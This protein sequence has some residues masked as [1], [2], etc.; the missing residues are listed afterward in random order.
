M[1]SAK[2]AESAK[3]GAQSVVGV[4]RIGVSDGL[5]TFTPLDDPDSPSAKVATNLDTMIGSNRALRDA[6]LATL[7]I[8]VTQGDWPVLVMNARGEKFTYRDAR[9]VID[10]LVNER[11]IAPGGFS[12]ASASLLWWSEWRSVGE[13]TEPK[14]RTEKNRPSIPDLAEANLPGSPQTLTEIRKQ[15]RESGRRLAE[16]QK[17][18]I[19]ELQ[20]LLDRLEGQDLGSDAV[21]KQLTSA[22]NNFASGNGLRLIYNGKAV[23]VVYVRDRGFVVKT[24]DGSRSWLLS[25]PT[26]PPLK[27]GS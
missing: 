27:A 19:D 9:R 11:S 13:V 23:N 17:P 21:N 6:L 20:S 7:S 8:L 1:V 25:G 4:V 24:S 3:G 14:Q 16:L 10:R 18:R 5:P 15:I 12:V 22:V 2:R 26:F